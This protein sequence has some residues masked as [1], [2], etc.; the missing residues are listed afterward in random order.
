MSLHFRRSRQRSAMQCT[1]P[2]RNGC[3]RCRFWGKIRRRSP[4]TRREHEGQT[5]NREGRKGIAKVAKKTEPLKS[6]SCWLE[7]L[8]LADCEGGASGEDA[9]EGRCD[10]H[11]SDG[12]FADEV[13][14]PILGKLKGPRPS[15]ARPRT[16]NLK[17]RRARRD[18]QGRKDNRVDAG[19]LHIQVL[20]S[21][22]LTPPPHPRYS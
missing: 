11:A 21:H 5:F 8:C 1:Q 16:A 4:R 6:W 2:R 3:G 20:V 22:F 19:C 14:V 12:L 10:L 13:G 7:L 15:L 17:P 9:G 18:R